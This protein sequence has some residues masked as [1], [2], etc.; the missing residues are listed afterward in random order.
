MHL[1]SEIRHG[2]LFK[3]ISTAEFYHV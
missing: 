3:K 2:F 1:C